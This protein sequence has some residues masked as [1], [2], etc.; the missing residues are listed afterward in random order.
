MSTQVSADEAQELDEDY[1]ILDELREPDQWLCWEEI[2]NEDG[3]ERKIPR[4]PDGSGDFAKSNDPSTWGSFDEALNACQQQKGVGI[5]FVLTE[6][7][8]YL[9]VDFDDVRDPE[10]ED[11]EDWVLEAID[12]WNSYTEISPSGTGLHV[13][14]KDVSEPDWWVD[15]EHIEVYD[16]GQ[17]ITVTD[18]HFSDTPTRCAT[19]S[20]FE[21]WLEGQADL[22]VSEPPLQESQNES[23]EYE[24]DIN[25]DVYDVLSRASYPEGERVSHPYHDSRTGANF[26]VFEGG[27]AW[28][29][30]RH[31]VT[32]SALHLIGIEEGVIGCGDLNRNLTDKEWAKIFDAGRKA[33]YELPKPS[34]ESDYSS[35]TNIVEALIESQERWI[36]EAEKTITVWD[37]GEQDAA[38]V[39]EIFEEQSLDSDKS[40]EILQGLEGKYSNAFSDFLDNPDEWTVEVASPDDKW[41]EVRAW[42]EDNDDNRLA[43]DFAVRLLREEYDFI[44]VKDSEQMLC[45]DDEKGVYENDAKK[46]VKQRLEEMLRSHYSKH[47]VREILA[48]LSSGSYIDREEFGQSGSQVCVGNGVLDIE[49]GEFSDFHPN[50]YFRSRLPVEYDPD[51]DC[52]QFKSFLDDVCPDGKIPMLQEFVGYC[53][54]PRM[55]HKKALLLLGPTDAGKSVF[56][57]VLEALFG[58]ESTT[59][60]SVQYLANNRWGEADLV[61]KIANIRHDLDS[62]AIENAGKIKELTAGDRVRAERKHEDPFFFQPR[63]K[64]IFSANQPPARSKEEDSGFWN[65][66]LTVVFPETIPRNEQDPRLTEKL[67]SEEELA[68]VLNWAVEGYQCL[69]AQ[70]HFTNEPRPMENRRLWEQYGNSVERFVSQHLEREPSEYVRKNKAY[71]AYKKFAK[72]EDMEVVTKHKFTSELKDKGASVGQRRF[73]EERERVYTGFQWSD[74]EPNTSETEELEAEIEELFG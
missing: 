41:R 65:R 16:S 14:L 12:E 69:E 46:V 33:G 74:E 24:V 43:R 55:H 58:T 18:E 32:G 66:W 35:P 9:A 36:S 47:E 64:H 31:E 37:V 50:Y 42:Y 73:D 57:D 2:E 44:T 48:R 38:E 1:T 51:A 72:A 22:D 5:G 68:G 19:P 40:L 27:E 7:D 53:L 15:T 29:C 59:S 63:T 56:L 39:K 54:Q 28:Y 20:N 25:I 60:H 13:W 49:T 11:I 34:G 10:T 17:Y 3:D 52:P 21:Q 67:T 6:D 30:Y 62:S 70:G 45:Y 26:R 71:D 4:V 8:P 23:G 61:G